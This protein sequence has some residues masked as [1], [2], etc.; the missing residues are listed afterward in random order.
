MW[1]HINHIRIVSEGGETRA[2]SDEERHLIVNEA[3]Q[4]EKL[5]FD[6]IRKLLPLQDGETFNLVRYTDSVEEAEKKKTLDDLKIYHEI[7]KAYGKEGKELFKLLTHEQLDA[8]GEAFSKNYSDDKIIALLTVAGI[9]EAEQGYLLKLTNYPKYGHLSLKACRK[10]L[11]HLE[12]GM[13]YDKACEMAGYDFKGGETN[14][15]MTLPP[16]S[17]DDESIITSPVVRRAVSQSI[18]VINAIIREMGESPVYINIELARELSKNMEERKKIEKRQDENAERN[19]KAMGQ[20]REYV[21][22][23]TGFDLVKYKLWE[24]Q[25]GICPYSQKPISLSRLFEV[26]YVDVDHIVPYSRSFDDR[27]TNKVLVFA[28]ENRQKGNRLPLEYLQGDKRDKFTVWVKSCPK[29]TPAKR[30]LLLKE[31]IND[32]EGF[33]ARNLQDTQF[34]TSFL[35]GFIVDHLLFAPS[36]SGKKRRVF[37]V[38]GAITSYARKRWG[39][40]KVREDGD[41]HHALD[42][43]VIAC[44]TPGMVA[45]ITRYMKYH[46]TRY[47]EV[48]EYTVD[49]ATGEVVERFPMPWEDFRNELTI[50]LCD[51]GA[52][53]RKQLNDVNFPA[54]LDVDLDT[55]KAPFVSRMSNHKIT[56][57]AHK[58]TMRSGRLLSKGMTV[59]KV[60]LTSL[61]LDK[62]GEI[63]DYYNPDSDRLL[64]SALKKRLHQF[65]GDA[66]KAFAEPF[67]KPCADGTPGPVVKKV[68]VTTRTSLT[69]DV[70]E[71]TAVADNDTMVR[72]DVFYVPED[73]YY[74]VPVY[75]ADTVK[76][77]LPNK[78]CVAGGRPWKVMDEQYFVFS[79]YPRDLIKVYDKKDLVLKRAI[80]GGTL[81]EEKAHSGRDGVFLYYRG[82]DI[83]TGVLS[84]ITHDGTYLRRSIGKTTLKIEKYTVDVL[85]NIQRVH[86]ETRQGFASKKK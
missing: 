69:V 1:Q 75:V 79:L 50:R 11:P 80:D 28:S 32:E 2:L 4:K 46:E 12:S 15:G 40:A 14:K 48:G 37:T 68:K 55:V 61:K 77:T 60:D 7:R 29:F 74:F 39:L 54:Y 57:P 76:D 63:A 82:L 19:E 66:K 23:P 71:H 81:P 43:T 24:E 38:N 78:A 17:A 83:A 59:S 21:E 33:R 36:V 31:A 73:G 47:S 51:D 45:K 53:L 49:P 22:N 16:L 26:G 70:L 34:I 3:H 41:L 62:N 65:D 58:E 30:K 42:A 9:D 84:G 67:H 56:G 13:T 10:L 6:R 25:G 20:V 85:G 72:C 86:K 5:T 52:A 18:K 64:Y 8:I 35:Y 27:M 44:I